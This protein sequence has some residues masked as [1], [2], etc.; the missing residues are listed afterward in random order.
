MF[1]ASAY[2]VVQCQSKGVFDQKKLRGF[3]KQIDYRRFAVRKECRSAII[4]GISAVW[5]SLKVL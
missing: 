5:V 4:H 1:K 2:K 3:G